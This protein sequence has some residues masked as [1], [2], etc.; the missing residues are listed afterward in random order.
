MTRT[1]VRVAL[2]VLVIACVASRN[3]A[4]EKFASL[5]L[6]SNQASKRNA[7][8]ASVLA[9]SCLV[10]QTFVEDKSSSW[11]E[12]QKE[13]VLRR[14]DES[15]D[16]IV[17]ESRRYG[18]TVSFQTDQA[19]EVVF[20]G[21]VPRSTF[22]DPKWT[23]QIIQLLNQGSG[24][25]LVAELR[26]QHDVDSVILCL[27]VNKPALSYNLAHYHGVDDTYL[28]E[29]MICFTRYPDG[30]PTASATYAHETLHLFGAGDLYFP[31]DKGAQR[32]DRARRMFPDDVMRRVDYDI[33]RLTVG[34]FSAFR[35]GWL[36]ELKPQYRA[37]E[38]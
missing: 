32:K 25:Q 12:S 30:R 18:V 8:S 11:T 13:T 34:P 6:K 19:E 2:L 24:N 31:Y 23:E 16:F 9:G 36:D 21:E 15:L 4:A 5:G 26:S 7:G 27:H 35:V 20:D 17:R 28:S 14:M 1:P 29:R 38:D 22:V 10:Y 37:F 3:G 33:S